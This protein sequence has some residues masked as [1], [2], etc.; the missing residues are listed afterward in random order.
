MTGGSDALFGSPRQPK[1]RRGLE[2]SCSVLRDVDT[3]VIGREVCA[4]AKAGRMTVAPGGRALVWHEWMGGWVG[5]WV[6]RWAAG[7]AKRN[8][9]DREL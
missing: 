2:C 1:R 8:T 7:G 5:G 6:N 3:V 9:P 4:S